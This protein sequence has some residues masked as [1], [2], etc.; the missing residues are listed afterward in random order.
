MILQQSGIWVWAQLIKHNVDFLFDPL[1]ESEIVVWKWN[2]IF[3]DT[4]GPT[5]LYLSLLII[6]A[7][8]LI[9]S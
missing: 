3:H 7:K 8:L 6:S 1:C 9:L 2:R 4:N 5:R